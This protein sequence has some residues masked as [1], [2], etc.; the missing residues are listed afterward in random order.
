MKRFMMAVMLLV[1]VSPAMAARVATKCKKCSGMM[2]IMSIGKCTACG[3][4][5]SSGAYKLCKTCA[6]KQGK[7]QM[8]LAPL[9]A[10]KPSPPLLALPMIAPGDGGCVRPRPVPAKPAW[11]FKKQSWGEY[12]KD[13]AP[14]IKVQKLLG[15]KSFIA[16]GEAF[17][18]VWTALNG[19]KTA[20]TISWDNEVVVYFVTIANNRLSPSVR[21]RGNGKVQALAMSTM[22]AGP[23]FRWAMQTY[24]RK[25]VKTINGKAVPAVKAAAPAKPAAPAHAKCKKCRG[26]MVIGSIGKCT[27]CGGHT[28]SGAYKLCKKCA[29]KQGKCQMCLAPLGAAKPAPKPA[30][31]PT[32][33]PPLVNV[34]GPMPVPGPVKPAWTFK[35][36]TWGEY[37]KDRAPMTAVKTLLDGKSFIAD[38]ETFAKV[39]TALNGKKAVPT[40]SW[41]NEIVIY[42][43]VTAN[44]RLRPMVRDTN[45]ALRAMAASTRMG[46]PGFRW[47][48]QTHPRKGVK[49]VNGKAVPAV[50]AAAKV[51][52]G[53]RAI[54][55][56]DGDAGKSIASQVGDTILIKLKSNPTT[57]YSWKQTD[58][59]KGSAVEFKSKKFLT[60]SQ[61]NPE[62]RTRPGQVGQGGA[63]TFIYR[64]VATG[65]ATIHLT[66]ARSWEKG[67]KEPNF[68]VTVNAKAADANAPKVTGQVIFSAPP[69]AKKISRI[70][71]TIRDVARMDGPSP[72]IGQVEIKGPFTLPVKFAI[73]YD[74]SKVRPNPMFYALSARVY[75]VV[76][77]KERLYYI[78]DTRHS[79]FKTADDTKMDIKVK[80]LR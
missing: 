3:G 75:T 48:M 55:L 52:A 69:D 2:V 28:S 1:L 70:V 39:W 23:G 10:P 17:A 22:M 32:V 14:M 53:G 24:P 67:K 38:G 7:C 42:F 57:G 5:T 11:T 59:P 65:K 33:C 76:D 20:P 47:L 6:A 34:C 36:Q 37:S 43:S 74:A 27:A 31:K 80:K 16:D 78:N 61:M 63:T 71:V 18:K 50:K 73:P 66:Y 40:I 26:M 15:G 54:N 13:R 56:G 4:H 77:G 60:M 12:S 79:I 72:L 64:V 9:A 51:P 68:T 30:P 19:K 29:V 58:Q 45:G 35:K 62:I 44:N 21:D 41:K 46:G 25:G 8:C 49:S